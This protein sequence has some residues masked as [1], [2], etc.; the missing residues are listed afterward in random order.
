LLTPAQNGNDNAAKL[1]NAGGNP[2]SAI[3]VNFDCLPARTIRDRFQLATVIFGVLLRRAG[4][5]VDQRA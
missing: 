5:N 4:T 2:D 3:L 1:K